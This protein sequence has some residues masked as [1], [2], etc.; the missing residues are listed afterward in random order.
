[1]KRTHNGKPKCIRAIHFGEKAEIS[2]KSIIML[3]AGNASILGYT[4]TSW[5]KYHLSLELNSICVQTAGTI[6]Y[7][8][9]PLYA[10]AKISPAE[11]ITAVVYIKTPKENRK[12][13]NIPIEWQTLTPKR[14]VYL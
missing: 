10:Q 13:I 5:V 9:I 11:N 4:L 3:I 7:D 14:I 8:S 12:P 2:G 6:T 1:M